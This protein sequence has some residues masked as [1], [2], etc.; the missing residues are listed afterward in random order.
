MRNLTCPPTLEYLG[1]F[2]KAY[3]M[4]IQGDE[5]KPV[6]E[7]Y[8]LV[9]LDPEA[10]YPAH[11]WMSALNEL[12]R[13]PNFTQNLVAIGMEIGKELPMPPGMENAR[14]EQVLMTLDGFYQAA[15]R[16]GDAGQ[17]L[18]EKLSDKHYRISFTDI[19][20]DDMSYGIMYALV[21]RFIPPKTHFKVDY[22]HD[23]TA[24]DKG[25]TGATV[26]HI[27]ME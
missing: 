3:I 15:H 7:K 11:K 25:G 5:T 24:R 2:V 4:N 27:I 20:P 26:M 19:Y 1:V 17:I 9:D 21:K 13:L 18:S 10:W 6:M 12:G 16:N 14:L 8:G 22:D 23:T